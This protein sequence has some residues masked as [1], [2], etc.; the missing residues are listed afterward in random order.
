MVSDLIGYVVDLPVRRAVGDS[1]ETDAKLLL[2]YGSR[3]VAMKGDDLST[4]EVK[5]IARRDIYCLARG[6]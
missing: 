5:H 3:I 2:H 6:S 1:A 4:L